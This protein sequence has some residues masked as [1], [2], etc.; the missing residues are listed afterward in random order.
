MKLQGE[1]RSKMRQINEAGLEI[2]KSFEGIEDGDPKTV[3]LDPYLDPVGIWTIG[4]GH[5]I[6]HNGKFVR[7]KENKKLAFSLYENGITYQEAEDLLRKD[8]EK[9]C[10]SIERLVIAPLTDNQFSSLVSWTFNVGAGNLA[11]STLLRKLN[12][13]N[14]SAVPFQ[15]KRWIKGTV[16]G[17]RV[18]LPGLVRRREAEA[19]L[20]LK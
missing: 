1:N 11:S 20:W 16:D 9:A 15:M 6:V 17:V 8:V 19:N 2:I 12:N 14:Y 3:N 7:G 10:A 4:W 13:K 18:V 5:A